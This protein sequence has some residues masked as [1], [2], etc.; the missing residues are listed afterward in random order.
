MK[1]S[2]LL[3]IHASF[4]YASCHKTGKPEQGEGSRITEVKRTFQIRPQTG[5]MARWIKP[6][7]YKCEGEEFRSPEPMWKP[8][9]CGGSL[10]CQCL[11]SRGGNPMVTVS[12][13]HLAYRWALGPSGRDHG[14]VSGVE[15]EDTSHSPLAATCLC[16]H[17]HVNTHTGIPP[18]DIHR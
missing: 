11:E 18:P 6:L 16:I 3:S 7:L 14:S 4:L 15:D 13:A 9:R 10:W 12:L 17:V 5:A 1:E 8:G 2:C